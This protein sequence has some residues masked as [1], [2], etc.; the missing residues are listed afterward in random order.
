[1]SCKP[2]KKYTR[3][4][5]IAGSDCGGCA[6]IQADIRVLNYL[7]CHASTVITAITAQNTQGVQAIESVSSKFV[8]TQIDS[9]MTDIGADAIKIGMLCNE[10]IISTVAKAL[11]Y[12]PNIPIVLDPVMVSTSKHRLLQKHAQIALVNNL[13]P[14]VDLVT[15]NYDEAQMLASHAINSSKDLEIVCKKINAL[16][17]PNVLITGGDCISTKAIDYYYQAKTNSFIRFE[18]KKIMTKND[19][20]SGCSLSCAIAGYLAKGLDLIGAIE[21]AKT[22]ITQGL[23]NGKSLKLGSGRGPI[24]LF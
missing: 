16:G 6:G 7:H 23:N 14:L 21:A 24:N 19:H 15:P 10:K 20:G 18:S 11:S 5:S 4:L 22:L 13:L 2:L 12:Y 9:V 8:S 17:V 3:V 1:M